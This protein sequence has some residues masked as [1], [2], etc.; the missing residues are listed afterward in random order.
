MK[1]KCREHLR[2]HTASG[3]ARDNYTANDSGGR[4]RT[5]LTINYITMIVRVNGNAP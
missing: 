5:L 3:G 1:H 2:S 4:G